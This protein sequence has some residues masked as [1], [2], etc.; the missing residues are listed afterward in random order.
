MLAIKFFYNAP[1]CIDEQIMKETSE[2]VDWWLKIMKYK[3][4][5]KFPFFYIICNT[6][7]TPPQFLVELTKE[8]RLQ[9]LNICYKMAEEGDT[10]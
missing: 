3:P 2:L 9:P 4:L 8:W 5:G 7:Y 10:L 6:H 1:N